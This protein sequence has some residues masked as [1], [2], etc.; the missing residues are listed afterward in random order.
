MIGLRV[1]AKEPVFTGKEL[2][3]K[4]YFGNLPKDTTDAQLS[5]MVTPYGKP[6]SANVAK[7]RSSGESKGF[8]FVEFGTEAE[9]RAAITGLD[10]K[11]FKGKALKVNEAKPS[12]PQAVPSA[13]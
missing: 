11:D 3:M 4:L 6:T 10:G 1:L 2:F 12:K 13:N 7:D 9:A 8:G 5:E